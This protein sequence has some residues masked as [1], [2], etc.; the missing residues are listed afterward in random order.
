MLKNE[1]HPVHTIILVLSVMVFFLASACMHKYS[2][3]GP[4]RY[5]K[6]EVV[7]HNFLRLKKAEQ[8][9][10]IMREHGIVEKDTIPNTP[11]WKDFSGRVDHLY[12]GEYLDESLFP[13]EKFVSEV[14]DIARQQDFSDPLKDW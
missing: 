14:L 10:W 8:A 6:S 7:T 3:T 4:D 2:M 1:F 12:E 11:Y 9:F 5:D 13:R